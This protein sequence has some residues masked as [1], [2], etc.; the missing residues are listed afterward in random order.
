MAYVSERNCFRI[1]DSFPMFFKLLTKA[2]TTLRLRNLKNKFLELPDLLNRFWVEKLGFYC[3]Q[4]E[5]GQRIAKRSNSIFF[6]RLDGYSPKLAQNSF[7]SFQQQ[8]Q[9]GLFEL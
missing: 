3:S 9:Q 4:S 6:L 2:P 5:H 8:Q 7:Q 1:N